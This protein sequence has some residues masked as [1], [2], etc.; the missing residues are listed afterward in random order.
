LLQPL[1]FSKIKKMKKFVFG[2]LVVV[3]ISWQV[4]QGTSLSNTKWSGSMNVPDPMG[5]TLEF[6]KDTFTVFI[7]EEIV[8]AM[9]YKVKGDTLSITKLFGS[10]PCGEEEGKYKYTIKEDLLTITAI[11]EACEPRAAAFSPAGYK[12][13]K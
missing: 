2:L 11:E 10:S 8:E 3:A 7:G 13:E 9:S 12:K 6:K 5:V 1:I 4:K